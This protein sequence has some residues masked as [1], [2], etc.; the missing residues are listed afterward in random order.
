MADVFSEEKR[1]QIMRAVKSK[2]TKPEELVRKAL[3]RLK[4]RFRGHDK[5]LPGSPD[6]VL[7]EHNAVIFVNGC[8]WHGHRNCRRATIPVTRESFWSAKIAKNKRR[9][10][11]AKYRLTRCG[12]RYLV[13]WTCR[14]KSVSETERML[15]VVWRERP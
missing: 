12:M 9:D 15:A 3:R 6:F 10:R 2:R 1:R 8:F 5:S 13:L 4:V 7:P 11:I 14:L